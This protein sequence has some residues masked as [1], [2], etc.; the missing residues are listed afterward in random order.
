MSWMMMT[1]V[2]RPFDVGKDA[3]WS[4]LQGRMLRGTKEGETKLEDGE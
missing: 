3:D 2:S 4:A 1:F